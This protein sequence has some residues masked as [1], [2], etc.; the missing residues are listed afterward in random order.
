MRNYYNLLPN[1]TKINKPKVIFTEMAPLKNRSIS[2]YI[3][4]LHRYCSAKV[5]IICKKQK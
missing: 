5:C 4:T 1:I 2:G 3:I